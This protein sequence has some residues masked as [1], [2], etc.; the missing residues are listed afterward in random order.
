[1]Q[2]IKYP[3]SLVMTF[4]TVCALAVDKPRDASVANNAD[5]LTSATREIDRYKSPEDIAREKEI[6]DLKCTI[7]QTRCSLVY[8]AG[9][10]TCKTNNGNIIAGCQE[11]GDNFNQQCLE[12]CSDC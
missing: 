6:K 4:V 1:M 3:A 8:R 7:C 5:S 11:K 10:S 2:S 9:T 12:Q